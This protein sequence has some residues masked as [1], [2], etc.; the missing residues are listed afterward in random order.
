[1]S[2]IHSVTLTPTSQL[3]PRFHR[4][5]RLRS[6]A[7]NN[8]GFFLCLGQN[9]IESIC[10]KNATEPISPT[11]LFKAILSHGKQFMRSKPRGESIIIDDQAFLRSYDHAYT[12]SPLPSATC[13]FFIVFLFVAGRAYRPGRGGGR[14]A[15]SYHCENA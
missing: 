1:L 15:K 5:I 3:L 9:K 13:L 12:L 8:L 7:I 2:C 4:L 10:E 11:H 14:G 6:P